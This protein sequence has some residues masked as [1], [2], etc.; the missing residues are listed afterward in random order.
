[1]ST[2]P[3][4]RE[5]LELDIDTRLA[6]LWRI[7]WDDSALMPVLEPG[8]AAELLAASLRSSYSMGYMDAL[9]EDSK[10]RRGELHKTHGYATP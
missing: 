9:V 6:A 7:L 8:P 10:G 4:R 3:N 2:G 1:V 5:L